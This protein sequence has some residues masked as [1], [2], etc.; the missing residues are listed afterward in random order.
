[1]PAPLRRNWWQY[2][3]VQVSLGGGLIVLLALAIAVLRSGTSRIVVYND[4]GAV[5]VQLTITACGQSRTFPT[6]QEGESVRLSLDGSGRASDIMLSTHGVTIWRGEYMEPR[7][8]Y[9]ALL[10]LRRDGQADA[11]TS[12]SWWQEMLG[13]VTPPSF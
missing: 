5:L 12:I 7:G 8:G 10:H 9:R 6:I 4:T 2:R 11:S 3:R 13:P 1:M